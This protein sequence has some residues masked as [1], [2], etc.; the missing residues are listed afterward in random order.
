MIV[1]MVSAS[2][3]RSAVEHMIV[4]MLGAPGLTVEHCNRMLDLLREHEARSIDAYS[5]G[6]RAEYISS[7]ATLHGLIYSQ[8]QLRKELEKI[9]QSGRSLDCC[10]RHR[11]QR[12]LSPRPRRRATSP[13][14]LSEAQRTFGSDRAP[15]K[16][17]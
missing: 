8:E 17:R 2:A 7:R 9:R 1:D 15:Q 11:A 16:H 13:R 5:E 14:G 12:H 6:L 10:R 4:P 3:E